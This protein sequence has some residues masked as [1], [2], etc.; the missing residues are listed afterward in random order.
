[1]KCEECGEREAEYILLDEGAGEDPD[2]L[3]PI[4]EQCY[5]GLVQQ[6]G[7]DQ[8]DA[9]DM[10]D[11]FFLMYLVD[12]VNERFKWHS[13]MLKRLRDEI[14]FREAEIVKLRKITGLDWIKREASK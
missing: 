13:D 2:K 8:V 5:R 6:F 11:P 3:K 10:S 12:A 7:E 14:R 4:C 9:I 1:M